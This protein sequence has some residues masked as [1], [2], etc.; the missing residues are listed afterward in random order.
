MPRRKLIRHFEPRYGVS[1]AMIDVESK[2]VARE[3][4]DYMTLSLTEMQQK[5]HELRG[6]WNE[7]NQTAEALVRSLPEREA[8]AFQCLLVRDLFLILALYN[9]CLQTKR[10]EL[11]PQPVI[12]AEPPRTLRSVAALPFSEWLFDP[13]SK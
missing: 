10:D 12:P 2:Y 7:A 1:Q 9:A 5:L 6:K 8:V 13:S 4:D 3:H 11:G